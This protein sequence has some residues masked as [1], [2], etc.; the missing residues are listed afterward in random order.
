MPAQRPVHDEPRWGGG[1]AGQHA[2]EPAQ[3][4]GSRANWPLVSPYGEAEDPPAVGLDP[5]PERREGR[6]KPPWQSDDMPAEPPMLRLVEP[7]P[8]ADP[9]LRDPLIGGYGGELPTD[10]R[11]DPPPLRLVEG[12]GNGRSIPRGRR[13]ALVDRSPEPPVPNGDDNDLLIFAEARSAW[14]TGR[15]EDEVPS[16]ETSADSGWQAAELAA[17]PSVGASNTAGLPRRVPQANLVPGS[18]TVPD[19]PLRIVRDPGSIAEHTNG[20][21]RGWRRGREIGG[22]AVGGR[23]GRDS[24]HG[25]DFSRDHG[26]GEY[27]QQPQYEYRQAAYRS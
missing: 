2:A 5:L 18:P 25:W 4:P 22:Y 20:Y 19:R 11:L 15:S 26:S 13:N 27:E 21:F 10:V 1:D 24:A 23:P 17:E 3:P 16:W 7:P 8:L 6:V 12:E 14:F 9:A